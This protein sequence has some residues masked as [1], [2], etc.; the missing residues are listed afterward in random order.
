MTS[1]PALLASKQGV[2]GL[3]VRL[4]LLGVLAAAA[5]GAWRRRDCFLLPLTVAAIGMWV[6]MLSVALITTFAVTF[7]LIVACIA[8]LWSEEARLPRTEANPPAG[9]RPA[10]GDRLAGRA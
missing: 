5:S 7:W 9:A 3:V 2:W 4:G 10:A 1:E 8:T 6:A